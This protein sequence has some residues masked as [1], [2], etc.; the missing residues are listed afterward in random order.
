MELPSDLLFGDIVLKLYGNHTAII[1]NYK[2]ILLYT[3]TEVVIACKKIMLRITGEELHILYF[4]NYDMKVQGVIQ[5][6]IYM[7]NGDL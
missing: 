4:S 5:S 3:D 1:E 2:G 6:I 7:S